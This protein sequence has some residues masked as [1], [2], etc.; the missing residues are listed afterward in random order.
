MRTLIFNLLAIALLYACETPKEI[1]HTIWKMENGVALIEVE[2]VVEGSSATGYWDEFSEV[3]GF[4]GITAYRMASSGNEYMD[5]L[6]Q[7]AEKTGVPYK[8]TYRV[9]VP[10]AGEYQVRIHNYHWLKDGDNDAWIGINDDLYEKIWD[11]DTLVWSWNEAIAWQFSYQPRWLHK[12]V[13]T[14]SIV[15]RSENWVI[16]R[17]A[18]VRK[19]VPDEIW[20]D[21][22]LPESQKLVFDGKPDIP[23]GVKVSKSGSTFAVIDWE[24]ARNAAAYQIFVN[25]EYLKTTYKTVAV[26]GNLKQNELSQISLAAENSYGIL[27]KFNAIDI[28]TTDNDVVEVKCCQK[29]CEWNKIEDLSVSESSSLQLAFLDT[30]LTLRI[31]TNQNQGYLNVSFD[32]DNSKSETFSMNDRLYYSKIEK[33]WLK[34]R[35]DRYSNVKGVNLKVKEMEN[36]SIEIVLSCSYETLGKKLSIGDVFGLKVWIS[37]GEKGEN[38]LEF[39]LGEENKSIA[40]FPY[41][42][43]EV[44]LVE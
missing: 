10:E 5:P 19:D 35:A 29:S 20:Q 27:S 28:K 2:S 36:G 7:D 37:K 33:P 6:P 8:L 31:V 23:K 12:G 22:S 42:F 24:E 16:D 32:P 26:I 14:I 44:L 41:T 17:L 4:S 43:K 40:N 1:Q 38:P 25:G 9:Y 18:V 30:M 34:E 15:G 21:I 39:I 11:H 13:N 3:L